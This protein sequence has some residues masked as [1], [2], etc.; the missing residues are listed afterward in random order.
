VP[1]AAATTAT[2]VA[3]EIGQGQA[4]DISGLFRSAGWDRIGLVRDLAGI[5]RVVVAER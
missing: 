5:E 3:F 1:A 2:F 4:A